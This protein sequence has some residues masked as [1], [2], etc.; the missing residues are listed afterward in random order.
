MSVRV[1]FGILVATKKGVIMRKWIVETYH[2][3]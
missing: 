1:K 3:L 2:V